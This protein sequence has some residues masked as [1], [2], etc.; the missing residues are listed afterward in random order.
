MNVTVC[1]SFDFDAMSSWIYGYR[2]KSPNALSRGEFGA[3]GARRL[4]ELL[5]EREI[6]GTWFVPYGTVL[7]L[8]FT[9][10]IFPEQWIVF[11]RN[12]RVDNWKA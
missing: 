9:D 11:C 10:A 5:A 4:I 2:T 6:V 3:V 7:H 12:F 1:L 8:H